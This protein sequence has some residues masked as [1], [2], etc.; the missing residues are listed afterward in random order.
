VTPEEVAE[1]SW[2]YNAEKDSPGE[3]PDWWAVSV[4]MNSDFL[5]R[6]DLV[7][8]VVL[9]MIDSAPDDNAL[10]YVGASILEDYVSDN[11]DTVRWIE[12]QATKSERFRL[13]LQNVWCAKRVSAETF[14]RI[15]RAA[16]APMRPAGLRP[17]PAQIEVLADIAMEEEDDPEQRARLIEIFKQISAKRRY[18]DDR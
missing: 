2:R 9:A 6:P 11:E 14:A 7:R 12:E 18:D 10:G 4:R 3:H 13:A 1:A 15:E 5:A 17:T 8:A 16:G